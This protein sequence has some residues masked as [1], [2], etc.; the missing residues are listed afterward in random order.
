MK[1]VLIPI[2][3]FMMITSCSI[4]DDIKTIESVDFTK[5]YEGYL[6]LFR[7][8][9]LVGFT[10]KAEANVTS[11]RKSLVLN[12][13]HD[14]YDT[15]TLTLDNGRFEFRELDFELSGRV[16]DKRVEGTWSY[17]ESITRNGNF[18]TELDLN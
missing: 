9:S 7:E 4:D 18:W 10:V 5:H 15:Y 12:F 11:D 16:T 6:N 14:T 17:G 1:K 8:D 2:G 3:L 13:D